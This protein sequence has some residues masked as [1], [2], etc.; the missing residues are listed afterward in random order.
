MVVNS[1]AWLVAQREAVRP[2]PYRTLL[3]LSSLVLILGVSTSLSGDWVQYYRCADFAFLHGQNPYSCH[4]YYNTPLTFVMQAPFALFGAPLDAWAWA[5]FAT[6]CALAAL[7]TLFANF[8]ML[9][10]RSMGLVAT[11]VLCLLP[12]AFSW[13]SCKNIAVAT[14]STS[15]L[16]CVSSSAISRTPGGGGSRV[17]ACW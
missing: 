6:T 4:N 2:L 5:L 12:I 10:K 9:E 13:P 17:M 16:G 7:F 15:V 8:A 14:S 3:L 11:L 1:R